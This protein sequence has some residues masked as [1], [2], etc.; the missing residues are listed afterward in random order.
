[1]SR[2]I[3][4]TRVSSTRQSGEDRISLD[5]QAQKCIEHAERRGYGV[6]DVV[7]EVKSGGSVH[8]RPLLLDAMYRIRNGE[9]EVLL[10]Y[11]SDRL[12]RQQSGPFV[13]EEQIRAGGGA[14]SS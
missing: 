11:C 14:S 3:I 9:A 12:T 2:A 7:R 10:A 1:M 6:V 8:G 4:H 5:E 13:I